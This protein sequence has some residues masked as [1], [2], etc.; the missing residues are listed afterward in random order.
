M[1]ALKNLLSRR[2]EM[3]LLIASAVIIA[4]MLVNLELS[5]GNTLTTELLWV[6]GGY[7]AIF[8]VA[9]LTRA[10]WPRTPTRSCCRSSPCST[11]WAW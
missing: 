2:M 6:I 8:T 7:V 5:Q 4:V 9:H 3:G 11:D 10:W 1:N